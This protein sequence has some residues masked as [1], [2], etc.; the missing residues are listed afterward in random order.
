[1]KPR[2]AHS[3]QM[4]DRVER[5]KKLCVAAALFCFEQPAKLTLAF[6]KRGPGI[7]L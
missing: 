2:Q 1:M 6:P 5:V 4:R 3:L 7:K